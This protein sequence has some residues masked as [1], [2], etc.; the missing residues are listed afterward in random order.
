[1]RKA[2]T[3][4]VAIV[5]LGAILRLV[6]FGHVPVAP[7]WDEM[8]IWDDAQSILATGRDMHHR[9]W[10][11]PLFISYGDFKLPVYIWLTALGSNLT[12]DILTAV[13]LPSLV[14]GILSIPVLYYLAIWLWPRQRGIGL[15]AAGIAAIL[16][17]SLHFSRVGYEGH[18]GMVWLLSSAA[19]LWWSRRQKIGSRQW[20]GVLLSAGLGTLAVYTYFSVRFVFPVV[21]LGVAGIEWPHWR[22]RWPQLAL[23][24]LLWLAL[25]MPMTRADFYQASNQFR[26]SATNI[27][28]NPDQPNIINLWRFRS[29]NNLFSR[30]VFNRYTFTA[31]S[32][33]VNYAT[34][35][36]PNYLWFQ[37][38]TNVR[39]SSGVTGI[40]L[41]T[42]FPLWV[43]GWLSLVRR[44][45]KLA[46][47]FGLW[48]AAGIL[49]AAVPTDVPHALRSLNTLPVVV[50]VLAWGLVTIAQWWQ[51][52]V[53]RFGRYQI[54]GKW[55]GAVALSLAIGLELIRYEHHWLTVY[56]TVSAQEWQDGYLAAARYVA[57]IRNQYTFVYVDAFDDRF[58]LY[59][60]PYSGL[61]WSAIQDSPSDGFK[62]SIFD[63]VR[64]SNID[65]WEALEH[66]SLVV[67]TPDRLPADQMV[68][69]T[70]ADSTGKDQF[71]TVVTPRD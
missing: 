21:F 65:N 42:M 8:A 25:L 60:L 58:F 40:M 62:R 52:M 57:Q 9:S 70:L 16:P 15:A 61:S 69:A 35:L 41:V 19:A 46:I 18:V 34:F 29:G 1:M 43:V 67:T 27:L 68:A 23:A 13:R 22:R 45:P 12:Q 64:I 37:G 7:Y 26:L 17:W 10:L 6:G 38:D 71:V 20:L 11:Q 24:L 56:P 36:S 4:L 48:W 63:N 39:H 59:Y 32:L 28:N 44:Q 51:T 33:M 53:S 47:Y 54:I 49:P 30:L 3:W 50:L 66:N 31:H 14:A 55:V 2:R 5:L